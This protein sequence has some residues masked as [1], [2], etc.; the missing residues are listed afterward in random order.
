MQKAALGFQNEHPHVG[1]YDPRHY[2]EG[3]PE[4]A[5]AWIN[6]CSA[7]QNFGSL[8]SSIFTLLWA[9]YSFVS[10]FMILPRSS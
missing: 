8:P 5:F 6:F 7:D 4:V 3:D 10:A 9:K 2:D 1:C